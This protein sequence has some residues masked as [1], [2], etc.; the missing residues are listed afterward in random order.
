MITGIV[1]TAACAV[2][3]RVRRKKK[4]KIHEIIDAMRSSSKQGVAAWH[5]IDSMGM[6]WAWQRIACTYVCLYVCRVRPSVRTHIANCASQGPPSSLNVAPVVGVDRPLEPPL[7]QSPALACSWV[8]SE[9]ARANAVSMTCSGKR[10]LRIK[11]R[12]GGGDRTHKSV[13]TPFTTGPRAAGSIGRPGMLLSRLPVHPR[14]HPEGGRPVTGV[15]RG[16]P[17][18]STK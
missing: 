1:R 10:L 2:V 3:R 13:W 9:A 11:W 17:R 14:G 16:V 15:P 7:S 18:A 5:S 6:T 12:V 4:E 8:S